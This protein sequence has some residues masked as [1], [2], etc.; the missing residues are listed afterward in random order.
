MGEVSRDLVKVDGLERPSYRWTLEVRLRAIA[1]RFWPWFAV[2]ALLLAV[3]VKWWWE[4]GPD[5]A[6]YLS[7]AR[8]MAEGRLQRFE[9]AHVRYAPAYAALLAPTFLVSDEPFL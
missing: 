8:N 5:A 1:G 4:P 6:S 2:V 9:S 7:I 3:Q